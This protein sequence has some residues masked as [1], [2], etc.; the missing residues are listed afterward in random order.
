MKAK[1]RWRLTDRDLGIL[2]FLARYGLGSAEQVRREFFGDSVNGAYRRLKGL[3]EMKLVRGERVF[4]RGPGV[5]R[6]TEPGA[7][8][9]DVDLPPPR[10]DRERIHHALEVIELSWALRNDEY[11]EVEEWITERELRRD[12]MIARR[13][14]QTGRMRTGGPLGRTPDGLMILSDGSQIAVEL[15]LS[16]KRKVSY[17]RIF[18]YYERQFDEHELDGVRFYFSSVKA[19]ERVQTIAGHHHLHGRVEFYHYEPILEPRR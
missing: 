17:R 9:A 19:M 12:R 7:R 1:R 6:V 16:P 13:E 10:R 8:L 14:E 11:E 18:E 4:Y 3:E 2:E 15:E 5:F